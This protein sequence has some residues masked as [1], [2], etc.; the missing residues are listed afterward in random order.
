MHPLHLCLAALSVLTPPT[1]QQPAPAALTSARTASLVQQDFVSV[2]R[3][4]FPSVVTV[5]AYA[6]SA[7]PPPTA[8][9]TPGWTA[10]RSD[11]YPGFTAL[12][13]ASGFFVS[14]DGDVLTCLH[15]LQHPDNTLAE[16]VEIETQDQSRILCE[17]V[18]TEPTLD[19][20]ILHTMVF[21]NPQKPVIVPLRFGDSDAMECGQWT[22][23]FGDPPGPGRFLGIGVLAS[24]PA[25]D[26]YQELLSSSYLQAS[27]RVH[28]GAYGGPLVNIDGDVVGVLSPL[29]A[30]D[31]TSASEADAG[32]A[33]ALPSK[34]VANLYQAIRKARTFHSPWL[35][36]AVMSRAELAAARGFEAFTAMKKPRGGIMIENVFAPSPA[37]AAGI[38]PGDFLTAFDGVQVAAPVDFQRMLYL[39]GIGKK[40]KLELFRDGRTFAAELTIERRPPEATPR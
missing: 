37:A 10:P 7:A 11:G 12:G 19:L 34:I 3:N 18:G 36:F 29:R 16:L 30:Q 25:R 23:A 22:L 24:K 13:S 32:T 17:V 40:V 39:A 9:T 31:G 38:E 6:R 21:S 26:C 5:R 2:A 20:A 4:T 35:G 1:P 33:Y 28:P 27:L 8:A 15:A 14:D